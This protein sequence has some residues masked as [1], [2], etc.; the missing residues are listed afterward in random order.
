MRHL[1]PAGLVDVTIAPPHKRTGGLGR[2]RS[3]YAC[4]LDD[5]YLLEIYTDSL[6]GDEEEMITGILQCE[7]HAEQGSCESEQ[8]HECSWD[9]T[10][11][12][13]LAFDYSSLFAEDDSIMGQYMVAMAECALLQDQATCS[14]DTKCIWDIDDD[15]GM[16]SCGASESFL[17]DLML[18]DPDIVAAMSTCP[19][20]ESYQQCDVD[21]NCDWESGYC[22]MSTRMLLD[23]ES[24]MATIVSCSDHADQAGCHSAADCEWNAA[25]NE[26]GTNSLL[27]MDL[28]FGKNS[29]VGKVMT[30]E[31]ECNTLSDE[32]ACASNADCEWGLDDETGLYECGVLGDA[33]MA[34]MF[35]NDETCESNI[36]A[37][38]DAYSACE[39]LTVAGGRRDAFS[40]CEAL[41]VAGG[42]PSVPAW[43]SRWQ[44]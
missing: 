10:D 44:A 30:M 7:T 24:L 34:T 39:A 29:T 28:M 22:S 8:L 6:E 17:Q 13:N 14:S 16:L 12:C 20:L 33:M 32:T 23:E 21:E 36:Q 38:S 3:N 11:G 19:T 35:A 2:R 26:C 15:T 43:R 40:A 1:A 31:S 37:Y 25:D 27:I 4:T 5:D 18:N 9:A 41:Q 42:M